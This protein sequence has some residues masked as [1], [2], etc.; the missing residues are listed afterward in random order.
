MVTIIFSKI[1]RGYSYCLSHQFSQG[2]TCLNI[3]SLN[4]TT[5]LKTSPPC[6][7]DV[8]A[9]K[10]KVNILPSPAFFSSLPNYFFHSV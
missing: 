3:T 9:K 5:T 1:I 10:D 7:L 8:Y 4:A 2:N 6:L